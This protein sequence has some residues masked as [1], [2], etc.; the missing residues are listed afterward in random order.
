MTICRLDGYRGTRHHGTTHTNALLQL[1]SEL[2]ISQ[3]L[4]SHLID[5]DVAIVCGPDFYL[6]LDVSLRDVY[7]ASRSTSLTFTTVNN[8]AGGV[9]RLAHAC[10]LHVSQLCIAQCMHAISHVS[11]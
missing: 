5:Y 9:H 8:D 11:Q 4:S 6:T 3:F 1:Y 2:R 7:A 10:N